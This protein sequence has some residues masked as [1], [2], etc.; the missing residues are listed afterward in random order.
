MAANRTKIDTDP[1]SALL[2]IV[3]KDREVSK[4]RVVYS[5]VIMFAMTH[6]FLLIYNSAQ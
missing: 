2:K 5:F 6:V 4:L 1:N 3:L